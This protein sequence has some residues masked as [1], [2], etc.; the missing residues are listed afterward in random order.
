[1]SISDLGAIGEFVA[2]IAVLITLGYLAYQIRQ[3]TRGMQMGQSQEFIRWN[4]EL[5]EPLVAQRDLTE[6]WEQGHDNLSNLDSTD[7]LRITLFEWRAIS[8]WHH[9]Y[10]MRKLGLVPDHLWVQLTGLFTR[11]G[12]REAMQ[13]AWAGLEGSL[14]SGLSG[15]Y[16]SVS[17][18]CVAT[19]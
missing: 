4:T 3:N 9:Y 13:Q 8:A 14:R 18:T 16:G 12:Q 2:S 10:H 17:G 1:M 19:Y 7:Q 6:L 5:V 15:F 11:I